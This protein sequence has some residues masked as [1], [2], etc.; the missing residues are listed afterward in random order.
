MHA[1]LRSVEE[2]KSTPLKIV[3]DASSQQRGELALKDVIHMG[4]SFVNKIHDILVGSREKPIIITADIQAG[5]TQI[6]IQ[7][8]HRDLCRFIW[9][10]DADK[11][12]A[13]GNLVE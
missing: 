13:H 6:R 9:V 4:M 11:P 5:F 12:P 1:T 10:R 3:F 7:E 8:S 2:N